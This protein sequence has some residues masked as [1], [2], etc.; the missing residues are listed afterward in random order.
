MF[1]MPPSTAGL[2][3]CPKCAG[4]A[5][6]GSKPGWPYVLAILLS[7]FVFPYGLVAWIAPLLV[8]RAPT[9]CPACRFLWIA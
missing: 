3:S 7:I 9:C 2:I 1:P 8:S 5:L 4:L 6:R